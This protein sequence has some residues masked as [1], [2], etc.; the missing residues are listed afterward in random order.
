MKNLVVKI[1]GVLF[2]AVEGLVAEG[3]WAVEWSE[4]ARLLWGVT[5]QVALS[6]LRVRSMRAAAWL[7]KNGHWW[8][9]VATWEACTAVSQGI[10]DY[11]ESTGEETS[12][13]VDLEKE[14]LEW[15]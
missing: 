3:V 7:R 15:Q 11:M 2:S 10:I 1:A 5:D 4:T 8:V 12:D 13:P 6:W 9:T 14:D